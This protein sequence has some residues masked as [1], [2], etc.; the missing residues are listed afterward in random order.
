MK[1]KV[2]R[3]FIY[4]LLLKFGA[5]VNQPKQM[6]YFPLGPF[7]QVALTNFPSNTFLQA[8]THSGSVHG[9]SSIPIAL[10]TYV[11]PRTKTPTR[12]TAITKTTHF[13]I[14]IS[15]YKL[16]YGI[17]SFMYL[18]LGNV[19]ALA[20]QVGACVYIDGEFKRMSHV[21]FGTTIFYSL[22]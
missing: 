10:S 5:L 11:G 20:H 15:T 9:F 14:A 12:I 6:Q 22:L 13:L 2:A 4:N 7:A 17:F 16:I 21:M 1:I 8:D 19:Y 3:Q 18:I